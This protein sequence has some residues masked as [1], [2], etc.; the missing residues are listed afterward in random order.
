ML[1][2]LAVD[3]ENGLPFFAKVRGYVN[4]SI[5]LSSGTGYSFK[6]GREINFQ[7]VLPRQR[8]VE[9]ASSKRAST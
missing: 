5:T 7:S 2:G 1:P 3:R 6:G 4:G 9:D 8:L